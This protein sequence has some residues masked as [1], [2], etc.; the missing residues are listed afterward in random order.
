VWVSH[1]SSISIVDSRKNMHPINVRTR[2]LPFLS[3]VWSSD[4]LIVAAGHDCCP[5][6]YY[7]DDRNGEIRFIDK[8]D[9]S[10]KKETDGFSAMQKFRNLD[11]R[12]IVENAVSNTALD[13]IHQNTISEIRLYSDFDSKRKVDKISSVG[14]DGQM[15]IWDLK[16]LESSLAN[17]QIK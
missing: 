12:A 5:M 6:L 4:N 14:V 2:Y 7:Y 17:L 8:I 15:V 16:T 3:C 1:D 11:K 10:T 9:K 13:T